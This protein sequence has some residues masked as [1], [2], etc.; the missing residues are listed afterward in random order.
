MNWSIC[1]QIFRILTLAC[2]F[3]EY[4][5]FYRLIFFLSKDNPKNKQ[6]TCYRTDELH[7]QFQFKYFYY[8]AFIYVHVSIEWSRLEKGKTQKHWALQWSWKNVSRFTIKCKNCRYYQKWRD[9]IGLPCI[10]SINC[11]KRIGSAISNIINWEEHFHDFS[12]SI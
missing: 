12:Y 11:I 7:T 10:N 2:L 4:T 5:L 6:N 1:V 3:V 9:I 8:N